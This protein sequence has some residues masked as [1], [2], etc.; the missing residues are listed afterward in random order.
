MQKLVYVDA[1]DSNVVIARRKGTRSI[2]LAV[3]SDGT[4]RLSI[5][6]AVSER[7]ALKFL[8]QKSDWIT[9]HHKRP[10]LLETNAH[11]GKSYTLV[12]ENSNL[13]SIKTRLLQNQVVI[14]LPMDIEW[15]SH[16]AQKQ[17]RKACERALKKQSETLLPQRLETLS[18]LHNIPYKSITVKKLKSRW[19]SCD[20]QKNI[21]LNIYLVQ[22]DWTLI[23]YVILHELAHTKHQHHQSDFW[24]YLS[25]L[26]PNCKG[27][28]K[29][30]K[31]MPTDILP[32]SF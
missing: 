8:E 9:K 30:L 27:L 12:Y 32:T 31:Q 23:D 25:E 22:L 28:R 26:L 4:I 2:R 24:N 1:I 15:N 29:Q 5:P 21:I 10:L 14:K 19:G 17:A 6:Y 16:D 20:T 18:K 3:R 7:Q 11:I 13:P